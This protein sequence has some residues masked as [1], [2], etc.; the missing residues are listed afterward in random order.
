MA[1]VRFSSALQDQIR[2]NARAKMEPA[3][4]RAKESRPDAATWGPRIYDTMFS[5]VLPILNQVPKGWLNYRE[6]IHVV[7]VGMTQCSLEFGLGGP[8]PWPMVMWATDKFAKKVQYRDEVTLTD[9]PDWQELKAEVDAYVHRVRTAEER[10]NEFV[11]A[12]NKV[13]N[14]YTTLAPALKAWP[15]LWDLIPEDVKDRHRQVAERT[16]REV[17]L[18]VDLNKLTALST[19]A[20]L[21]V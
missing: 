18:D 17:E 15:P 13:I 16:K 9:H 6:N 12:V 8:R 14:A 3:I 1:T 2:A 5:D 19:A 4:K 10:R 7:G 11:D 21:G 20:K